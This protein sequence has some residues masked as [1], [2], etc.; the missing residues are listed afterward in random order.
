MSVKWVGAVIVDRFGTFSSK[1]GGQ[2][3]FTDDLQRL[4]DLR[5]APDSVDSGFRDVRVV[6]AIKKFRQL[7]IDIFGDKING[8]LSVNPY[9]EYGMPMTQIDER[10][11]G[12]IALISCAPYVSL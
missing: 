10:S 9:A 4:S 6:T 12:T 2:R 3:L 11:S 5:R 7:S 1:K 8:Q